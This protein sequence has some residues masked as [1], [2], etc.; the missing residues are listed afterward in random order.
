MFTFL[1]IHFIIRNSQGEIMKWRNLLLCTPVPNL[2][3]RG[4]ESR[5]VKYERSLVFIYRGVWSDL[6]L[7]LNKEGVTIVHKRPL[8][9]ALTTY[10]YN[11]EDHLQELDRS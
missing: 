11:E 2:G 10:L 3:C 8:A 4:W 1:V 7:W 9:K 6:D 5:L